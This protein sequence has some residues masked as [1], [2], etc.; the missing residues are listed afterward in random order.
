MATANVGLPDRDLYE[1]RNDCPGGWRDGKPRAHL[2]APAAEVRAGKGCPSAE[3]EFVEMDG[4]ARKRLF[5]A[6]RIRSI[7]RKFIE[8]RSGNSIHPEPGGAPPEDEFRGRISRTASEAWRGI[9]S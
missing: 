7:Q 5:L 2:V 4:R 6:R 3:S 8:P 9:R 1:P